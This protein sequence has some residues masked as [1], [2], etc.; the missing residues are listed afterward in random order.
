MIPEL[1]DKIE[2]RLSEL[3]AQLNSLRESPASNHILIADILGRHAELLSLKTLLLNLN[4][5]K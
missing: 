1:L 5:S 3:N 2:K 4:L